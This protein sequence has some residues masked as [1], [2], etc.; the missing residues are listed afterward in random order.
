MLYKLYYE[1]KFISNKNNKIN[2]KMNGKEIYDRLKA[3][4][5]DLNQ[6]DYVI[7]HNNCQDGFGSAWIVWR[8]LKGDATYQGVVPDK[9]P[10]INVFRKK[11]VLFVDISMSLEYLEAVKAIANN[12]LVLDHHQ[13]FFE[14][15]K[16]HP[17]AIFDV[18]HSAIYITWRVFYPDQ[19]IPQFIR[20]IEDND[21]TTNQFSKTEAFVTAIGTKLPF[22]HIDYFKAWDKLLNP[23][24]VEQLINDGV[25]Y[26]EYKGYLLKRNMHASAPKNI[27]GYN[28]LISNFGT[29]GLASDLGNKISEANPRSDFVALWS[30]HYNTNEY[31]IILRTRRDNIDLSQIAKIYGGGGHPKAARFAWKGTI[32][33]LWIDMN[34][35]LKKPESK[36]QAKKKYSMKRPVALDVSD[37]E[38]ELNY[39]KP[40][41]PVTKSG[42]KSSRR[43]SRRSR[44]KSY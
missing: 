24:Y 28:V 42:S 33:D 11:Y 34:I 12:V 27:G 1:L 14:E 5:Y 23:S 17:N 39:V 7:Y 9:L 19:K 18:S 8:H 40:S 44:S 36:S 41:K 20:Y 10:N 21:L 2:L 35:K 26:Q 43:S 15:L 37:F 25:K 13:T 3:I 6:I 38:S 4:N 30:Y 29:V 32:E 31:S 16:D 22:H